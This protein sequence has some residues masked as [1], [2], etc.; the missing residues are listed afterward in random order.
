MLTCVAAE[1]AE[2]LDALEGLDVDSAEFGTLLARLERSVIVHATAEERE[3]FAQLANILDQKQL[4]RMRRAA[5]A[6][7]PD[8]VGRNSPQSSHAPEAGNPRHT[9]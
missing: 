9:T 2:D 3:E 5:A 1:A 4:E 8:R 7:R 6:P